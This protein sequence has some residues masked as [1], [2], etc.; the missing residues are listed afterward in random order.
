MCPQVEDRCLA[1]SQVVLEQ[2]QKECGA[3]IMGGSPVECE[4]ESTDAQNGALFTDCCP[5]SLCQYWTQF[6]IILSRSIVKGL[7]RVWRGRLA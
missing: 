2:G 4:H 1:N 7:V 6:L 3:G 5:A